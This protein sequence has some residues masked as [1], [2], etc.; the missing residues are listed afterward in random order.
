MPGLGIAAHHRLV[1]DCSFGSNCVGDLVDLSG[2]RLGAGQ[3]KD[4]VD[5]VLLTPGQAQMRTNLN[6]ARRFAGRR[7]TATGP[8]RFVS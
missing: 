6:A 3:A 7:T 1:V 2:Q 8:L 4:V 5:A